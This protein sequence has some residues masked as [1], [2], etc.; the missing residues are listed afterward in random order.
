MNGDL[1]TT[2]ITMLFASNG[3]IF[4]IVKN[5][6]TRKMKKMEYNYMREADEREHRQ[7]MEEVK[8]PFI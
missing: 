7:K 6:F 4:L 2:A 3:I 5:M 1:T 8:S